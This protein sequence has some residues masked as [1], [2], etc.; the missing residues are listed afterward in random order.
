VELAFNFTGHEGTD[1]L[2]GML[3]LYERRPGAIGELEA[4]YMAELNNTLLSQFEEGDVLE[5]VLKAAWLLDWLGLGRTGWNRAT[6]NA[7]CNI[8]IAYHDGLPE[9]G[10]DVLWLLTNMTEADPGFFFDA[11]RIVVREPKEGEVREFRLYTVRPA[12]DYWLMAKDVADVPAVHERPESWEFFRWWRV[13]WSKLLYDYLRQAPTNDT[14]RQLT[15]MRDLWYFWAYLPSRHI[16]VNGTTITFP[17]LPLLNQTAMRELFPKEF[18]RAIIY[19]S[20]ATPYWIE[21]T[22][23]LGKNDLQSYHPKYESLRKAMVQRLT[24]NMRI[25]T[26]GGKWGVNHFSSLNDRI[27]RAYTDPDLMSWRGLPIDRSDQEWARLCWNNEIKFVR[28]SYYG[29]DV[30]NQTL[31]FHVDNYDALLKS[32]VKTDLGIRFTIGLAKT[33]QRG[34]HQRWPSVAAIYTAKGVGIPTWQAGAAYPPLG[35]SFSHEGISIL[36]TKQQLDEIRANPDK[37]GTPLLCPEYA[38]C[39][40]PFV[41]KELATD[42][43]VDYAAGGPLEELSLRMYDESMWLWIYPKAVEILYED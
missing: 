42:A 29:S 7:V 10:R 43:G 14:L 9:L 32:D 39:L 25:I 37:Y 35:G 18:S 23:L 12:R 6:L 21:K 15:S 24:D 16:E 1:E 40:L 8:S 22:D 20:V 3:R 30:H 36:I 34:P 13:A 17:L 31:L 28:D 4:Q 27:V 41:S 5:L 2:A 11:P 26:E 38:I 33:D 19:M